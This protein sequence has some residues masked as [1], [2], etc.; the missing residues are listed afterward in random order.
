MAEYSLTKAER[1][2]GEQR[3]AR[4]FRCGKGGFV[5]P[6]RYLCL[7]A[8]PDAGGAVPAVLVSVSKRYHKRANRRNLL[9]RRVREAY[10]Q[11]NLPLVERVLLQGRGLDIALIY[12]SKEVV[13]YE[14]AENAVRKI[15]DKIVQGL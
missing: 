9:K 15:L 7:E 11:N 8:G 4:L 14:T 5:Y 1:L 2:S 6:F 13:S 10:R 3:I 12:S